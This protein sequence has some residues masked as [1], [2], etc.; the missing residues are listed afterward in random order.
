[1]SEDYEEIK[2]DLP[3]NMVYKLRRLRDEDY[4]RDIG[5]GVEIALEHSNGA[6]QFEIDP[7]VRNRLGELNYIQDHVAS[8]ENLKDDVAA[9]FFIETTYHA[10]K[11]SKISAD[12]DYE[13]KRELKRQGYN[14]SEIEKKLWN[15]DILNHLNRVY[16]AVSSYNEDKNVSKSVFAVKTL[17][18]TEK[19]KAFT[20]YHGFRE[21]EE[22][23]DEFLER[24]F[25]EGKL[26]E[27]ISF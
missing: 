22:E 27:E 2:V 23:A 1:M 6:D 4:I 24:Y 16:K 11:F 21:L 3:E 26:P 17:A 12:E 18:F 10:Q 19:Y 9:N 20:R 13:R 14:E 5:E 15:K 25:S 7:S 8:E